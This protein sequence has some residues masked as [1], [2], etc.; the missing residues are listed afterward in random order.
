MFRTCPG[1][2][3]YVETETF[4]DGIVFL[5]F[6]SVSAE[7]VGGVSEMVCAKLIVARPAG[8]GHVMGVGNV[9]SSMYFFSV[10]HSHEASCTIWR[11]S[12]I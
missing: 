7:T 1:R 12:E 4:E 8:F 3:K 11:Y 2:L 9:R 10:R 5:I 6:P